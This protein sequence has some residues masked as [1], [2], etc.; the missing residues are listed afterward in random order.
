MA[1]LPSVPVDPRF[2]PFICFPVAVLPLY[3]APSMFAEDIVAL[4]Y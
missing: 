3:G 2:S 1:F 4:D